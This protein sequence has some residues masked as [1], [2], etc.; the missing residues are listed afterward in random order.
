MSVSP[1]GNL[2]PQKL[3]A[4]LDRYCSFSQLLEKAKAEAHQV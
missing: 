3:F 2:F 4:G 1:G